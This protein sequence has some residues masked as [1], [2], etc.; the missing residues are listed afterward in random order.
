MGPAGRRGS[1][2]FSGSMISEMSWA[3]ELQT[4]VTSSDSLPVV[5]GL[6]PQALP[7][8]P[9]GTSSN[10]GPRWEL[11]MRGHAWGTGATSLWR[12]LVP[13]AVLRVPVG[14]PLAGRRAP[15]SAHGT[16]RLLGWIS[17]LITSRLRA[18]HSANTL[19]VTPV[20]SPSGHCQRVWL[21]PGWPW[22]LQDGTAEGYCN[23]HGRSAPAQLD[24]ATPQPY[25]T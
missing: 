19:P 11:H 25:P 10:P 4:G 20:S 3:R 1:R 2:I 24:R 17:R 8:L 21:A 22:V 5:M 18:Q 7:S 13:C 14:G 6:A 16:V 15:G 9:C 12:W 23:P